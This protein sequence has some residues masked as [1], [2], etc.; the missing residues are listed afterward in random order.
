LI[1]EIYL[2]QPS[3]QETIKIDWSERAN[4]LVV[5]GYTI[6]AIEVKVFDSGGGQDVTAS[7]VNGS[8]SYSG[9][10]IFVTLKNGTD[11]SD[12]SARIRVTF[13][14]TSYPDQIQEEDLRIMVRQVGT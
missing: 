7:M 8:P 2:K 12:Y 6:S 4:A 14:K 10:D 5:A 9:T 13:S 1:K 11:G 3:E